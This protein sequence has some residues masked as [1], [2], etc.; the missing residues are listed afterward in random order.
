MTTKTS[1]NRVRQLPRSQA[2]VRADEFQNIRETGGP[3]RETPRFPISTMLRL[4]AYLHVAKRLRLQKVVLRKAPACAWVRQR[5][6]VSVNVC[7]WRESVYVREG[8]WAGDDES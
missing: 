5:A 1:T 6:S 8:K 4:L 7:A 2:R 3:E